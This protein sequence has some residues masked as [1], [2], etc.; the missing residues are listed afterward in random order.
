MQLDIFAAGQADSLPAHLDP[1]RAARVEIITDIDR[2][3]VGESAVGRV[4][5]NREVDVVRVIGL[6][7]SVLLAEQFTSPA[8]GKY[9][10]GAVRLF[11]ELS[12]ALDRN[13][14]STLTL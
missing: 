1:A 14:Q 10:P 6:D 12:R 13:R 2:D 8:T 4:G 9:A 11:Q 3:H 7:G 5:N